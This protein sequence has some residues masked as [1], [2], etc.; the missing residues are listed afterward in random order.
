LELVVQEFQDGATP[1]TIVQQ[2]PSLKLADVYAVIGYYLGH[3]EEMEAYLTE[4]EELARD[5]RQRIENAQP[6][7]GGI[8]RRLLAARPA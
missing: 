2:F 1:E 8:R 5:V 7:L 4:R 6:D 3:R